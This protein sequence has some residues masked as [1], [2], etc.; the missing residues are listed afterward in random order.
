M[1]DRI[2]LSRA[3]LKSLR[4]LQKPDVKRIRAAIKAFAESGRGDIRKLTDAAQGLMGCASAISAS[5]FDV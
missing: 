1:N 3:A 4:R 2:E 5:S